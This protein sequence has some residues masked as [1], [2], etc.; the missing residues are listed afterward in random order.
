M[1][2]QSSTTKKV[3]DAAHTAV[4]K[5][6]DVADTAFDKAKDIGSAVYDKAKDVASAAVDKADDA[7]SAAGGGLKT[8]ADTVRHNTPHEGMMGAAS[9]GVASALESGGRYLQEQGLSGMAE[10]VTDLIKRNPMLAVLIG[11]GIGFLLAKATS[12]RS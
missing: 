1:A 3:A 10:D 12:S 2:N 7:A 5:G 8:L 11:V 9:T 4:D 6:K